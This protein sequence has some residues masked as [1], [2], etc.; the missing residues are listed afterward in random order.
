[1][2]DP[3]SAGKGTNRRAYS[4]QAWHDNF[5][6]I[7]FSKKPFMDEVKKV[8]NTVGNC[9]CADTGNEMTLDEIK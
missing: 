1:M 7:D 5:D 4:S 3:H 8:C 6:K 9:Q 2:S